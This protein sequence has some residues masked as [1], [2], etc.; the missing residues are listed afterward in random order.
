MVYEKSWNTTLYPNVREFSVQPKEKHVWGSFSSYTSGDS[1][2]FPSS[3]KIFRQFLLKMNNQIWF[4]FLSEAQ[5]APQVVPP[6]NAGR[7][8]TADHQPM[9]YLLEKKL[10]HPRL[11]SM[12]VKKKIKEDKKMDF[13]SFVYW[14]LPEISQI[15]ESFF[16][17]NLERS[18]IFY[19]DYLFYSRRQFPASV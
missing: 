4:Q 16:W 7:E 6:H 3:F 10:V 17:D 13:P 9:K 18:R 12:S 8:T 19:S 14:N 15:S 1:G 5:R 2:T 11:T